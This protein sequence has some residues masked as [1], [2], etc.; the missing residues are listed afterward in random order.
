MHGEVDWE[1]LL[2]ERGE[3][4]SGESSESYY[5]TDERLMKQLALIKVSKGV[6]QVY[7][8]DLRTEQSSI[9][10]NVSMKFKVMMAE[11]S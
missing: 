11:S 10:K 7:L 9:S 4:G 2:L 1:Y 3:L 8:K 6:R 5:A